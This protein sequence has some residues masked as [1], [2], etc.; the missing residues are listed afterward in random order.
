MLSTRLI[1]GISSAANPVKKLINMNKFKH[2]KWFVGIDISKDTIDVSVVSNEDSVK[3]K[4]IKISNDLNGF[5]KLGKW[6]S[7]QK[8]Q[9]ND[10]LFCMEH[11]GTY[12]LLLFLWLSQ[13]EI[14]YC[15]E[16]ALQIKRSLGMTR[17]KN[18]TIDAKRI[19]KY[20][21]THKDS[22]K[23]YELP[24]SNILQIKQLLTYR[25]QLVRMRSSLMNSIKSHVKYQQ[26]TKAEFVTKD[27]E[28][29]IEKLTES[30]QQA[31]RQIK[32][33][34]DQDEGLKENFNLA[35]SVKGIGL[36][37]AAFMIVTT[38]NFTSF[39][40]S[41]KYACY[42]GIAPFENTSGN[43][44]G[45]TRVSNLA[46]KTIKTLLSN[47]SN[48]AKNADPELR[49]YYKRKKQEGKDHKVIINAISFKLINRVFA[50]VARKTPYMVNYDHNFA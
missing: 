41:R 42:T 15:V 25:E 38:Q 18:D 8:V 4:E 43:F 46:N 24:A 45:K 36:I 32:E 39:E 23:A 22:L 19:A 21:R 44:I 10:A 11:T 14:D 5:D 34:I 30:I 31:E 6:L 29:N 28:S 17:G 1:K 50:V 48:S 33:L 12:G 20:A 47:G 13:K 2:K 16:P 35:T 37:I 3:A 40:N 9:M 27:I 7:K 49:T 26:I